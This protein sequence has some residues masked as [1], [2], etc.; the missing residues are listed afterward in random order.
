MDTGQVLTGVVIKE[1]EEQLTVLPNMLK[2]KKTHVLAK[3]SIDERQTSTVSSM[4][5]GLLDTFTID[6]I[7]DL[8]AYIQSVAPRPKDD[9]AE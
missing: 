3:A 1:S 2:P 6:E 8:V 7:L 9:G 5:V 4:P